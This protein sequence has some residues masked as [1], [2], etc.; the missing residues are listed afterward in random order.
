MQLELEL[1]AHVGLIGRPKVGMLRRCLGAKMI[2]AEVVVRNNAGHWA[3]FCVAAL[4]V[5]CN[6]NTMK[7]K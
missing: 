1:H 7:G 4:V 3:D 5:S 2:V 6:P